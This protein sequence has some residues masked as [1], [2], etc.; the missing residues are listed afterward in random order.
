MRQILVSADIDAPLYWWKEFDTYKVGTVA[1]STSTMHRLHCRPLTMDDFET[2]GMTGPSLHT[3]KKF[4]ADIE[5]SRSL[6][7]MT[8]DAGYW[9]DLI[10]MLPC[11]YKQLRTC[12]M[13]YEVLFNIY[14]ARQNH[15]LKEWH[16][17]RD[18][19]MTLP[20]AADLLDIHK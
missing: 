5:T 4:V 7:T 18:W 16:A 1:N 2:E 11:S 8:K 19:I 15:K 6:F 20:Y 14:H 17:F 3:F 13:N 9:N 12:T 10:K